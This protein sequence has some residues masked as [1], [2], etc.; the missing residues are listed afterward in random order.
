MV[1]IRFDAGKTPL[2]AIHSIVRGN[3]R[4]IDGINQTLEFSG[5]ETIDKI[6]HRSIEKE[7][8]RKDER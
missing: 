6:Y 3:V 7:K 1:K 8:K 5:G 2:S 4:L